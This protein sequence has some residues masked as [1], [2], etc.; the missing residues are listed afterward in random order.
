MSEGE[1]E[2]TFI[3]FADQA[4]KRK[5][6]EA[7]CIPC[8]S[9]KVKCD[10]QKRSQDGH[11]KCSNCEASQR[12]CPLRTSQRGKTRRTSTH[13][14]SLTSSST[15]TVRDAGQG[16]SGSALPGPGIDNGSVDFA[17]H[18]QPE[19]IDDAAFGAPSMPGPSSN[20]NA[21]DGPLAEASRNI[22][23]GMPSAQS[24]GTVASNHSYGDDA[25]VDA[26]YLHSVYGPENQMDAE[27]QELQAYLSP[28]RE[29][30]HSLPL[31]FSLQSA[32][33]ETYWEYCYCFCPVLDPKT[34]MGEM[35]RSPLLTNAVALAASHVQPPLLP[36]QGPHEYYDRARRLFYEDAEADNL[37]TLKALCLFYWWAPRPP[38]TIHRHTSW[39]WQSVIIR[40]AQQ[41]GIH[42]EPPPDSPL[43]AKL[44]LSVR[45][46]IW[47]TAFARER[48]TALCQSKPCIIDEADC[49]I[50]PPDLSDFPDDPKSQSKGLVF[51]HW[52]RLC[53]IIG[54]MAK[55]FC[56][57]VDV[58]QSGLYSQ[59]HDQ[60]SRWLTELPPD[61]QLRLGAN[62]HAKF[63][64]DVHQ[65]H[66]PY[67]TA[68]TI[69][70]LRRSANVLPQALPPAILA[71]S[72]TARVLRDVLAR[73]NTRFLMAITCWYCGTAFIA[74]LQGSRIPQF[75]EDSEEGIAVLTS[76]VEQLQKMWPSANVIRKG[77]DRMRNEKGA[78]RPAQPRPPT[79]PPDSSGL[80]VGG[81]VP[82]D[83]AVPP[84]ATMTAHQQDNSNGL[85]LLPFVTASTSKI[86]E[87]L[88]N[89]QMSGNV[90]RGMPSP[91]NT[92]FYENAMHEF[93]GFLDPLLIMGAEGDYLDFSSPTVAAR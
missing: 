32:F 4:A 57:P 46:R 41:M 43:R 62:S 81:V 29:D 11:S 36:H 35:A 1:A 20:G 39:W 93:H 13:A 26:G 9:K 85:S 25:C 30:A 44:D 58:D 61:L 54:R 24:I 45:R 2:P 52:V 84:H 79:I 86:A 7:V 27:M 89:N 50:A 23:V 75:A 83:P 69:L 37:T 6:A 68:V 17:P 73:G 51:I 49:T 90:T 65:L 22:V 74:L 53:A 82:G 64:R 8:H 47:W 77:F 56:R 38:S 40:H 60:L 5:R 91:R 12:D 42:R 10:V 80:A 67:L 34:I 66:L 28:G 88:L 63:D 3:H 16:A 14:G 76:M 87:C 71:A 18:P 19:G 59:Y 33:L 31:D 55:S 72:C 21:W 15:I 70:H 48:L 78:P 92:S